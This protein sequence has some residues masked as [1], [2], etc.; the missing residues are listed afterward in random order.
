MPGVQGPRSSMHRWS[1][2]GIKFYQSLSTRAGQ[3]RRSKLAILRGALP[4]NVQQPTFCLSVCRLEGTKA[5]S[6][7]TVLQWGLV[8][9]GFYVRGL[10]YSEQRTKERCSIWRKVVATPERPLIYT[11]CIQPIFV[12]SD[13][14]RIPCTEKSFETMLHF[15]CTWIKAMLFRSLTLHWSVGKKIGQTNATWH[16]LKR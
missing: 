11:E 5:T 9:V 15:N 8:G 4:F 2:A 7:R 12:M 3:L 16:T 1:I 13:H 10:M 14:F 6:G